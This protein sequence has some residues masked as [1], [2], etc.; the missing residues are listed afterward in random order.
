MSTP[1]DERHSMSHGF[2]VFPVIAFEDQHAAVDASQPTTPGY[3]AVGSP[4]Y[5]YIEWDVSQQGPPTT[6]STSLPNTPEPCKQV[7]TDGAISQKTSWFPEASTSSSGNATFR[8]KRQQKP[9][10]KGKAK[11]DPS[12]VPRPSNCFILFKNDYLDRMRESGC[13]I[14]MQS[15][16]KVIGA[17]WRAL[18]PEESQYWKDRAEK[19]EKKHKVAHPG[20]EYK[21]IRKQGRGCSKDKPRTDAKPTETTE[22]QSMDKENR[23]QGGEVSE[24]KSMVAST[25]NEDGLTVENTQL[26]RSQ[27]RPPVPSLPSAQKY[28]DAENDWTSN[29]Q[30]LPYIHPL[31]VS[32]ALPVYQ[33]SGPQYVATPQC[34]P[35]QPS[36]VAS[37]YVACSLP[38]H[39]NPNRDQYQ[40]LQPMNGYQFRAPIPIQAFNGDPRLVSASS[41]PSAYAFTP[42]LTLFPQRTMN[43]DSTQSTLPVPHAI[44]THSSSLSPS[45]SYTSTGAFPQMVPPDLSRT[46]PLTEELAWTL[47][48]LETQGSYGTQQGDWLDMRSSRTLATHRTQPTLSEVPSQSGSW[49]PGMSPD[50]DQSLGFQ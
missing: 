6:L 11:R 50:L 31:P 40:T 28:I 37:S 15:V 44:P 16:V 19:V 17:K 41:S 22:R 48:A 49:L 7:Q 24:D 47:A 26:Y 33:S 21:P 36:D 12:Y 35:A 32:S 13:K 43:T 42:N 30:F 23:P 14:H 18:P 46:Q 10:C 45:S 8:T 38:Y 5:A 9:V 25:C 34:Q 1:C 27:P 39:L 2:S 3:A 4:D 29:Q 20:Y